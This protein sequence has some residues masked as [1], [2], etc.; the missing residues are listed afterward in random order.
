LAHS[1]RLSKDY[2]ELMENS[3]A[4]FQIAMIRLT[5]Q[6]LGRTTQPQQR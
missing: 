5:L 2:E 1:R 3:E 4:M 6:R